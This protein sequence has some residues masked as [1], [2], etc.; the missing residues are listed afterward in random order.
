MIIPTEVD[1]LF[2]P[3]YV[4]SNHAGFG[5]VDFPR[6][7]LHLPLGWVRL[8]DHRYMPAR[9]WECFGCMMLDLKVLLRWWLRQVVLLLLLRRLLHLV[10]VLLQRLVHWLLVGIC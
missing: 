3:V 10:V 6:E 4:F 2:R 1:R 9:R 5:K 7:F 8:V